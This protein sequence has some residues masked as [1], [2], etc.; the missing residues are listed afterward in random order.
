MKSMSD[1]YRKNFTE[2]NV[3]KQLIH[4]AIPFLLAQLL[5]AFYSLVDMLVVGR[6]MGDM[7]IAAVNNST[8]L[9]MFI[10]TFVSGFA[11]SGTVLV[12]QY[13]GA[14]EEEHAKATIGTMFTLFLYASILITVIG[15][16]LDDTFLKILNTPQEAYLEAKRYL[17]ICFTGTIFICG[18]NGV[19]AVL[20]GLG[21]SK[22]PLYFVAIATGVNIVLD[23]IFV[24]LLH[25]GAGG[26]ALATVL[27]QAL[28]F[29]LCIRTLYKQNFIF[30]FKKE[31]FRIDKR[32]LPLIF[33]IGTPSAIQSGIVNFSFIF[34]ISHI[35]VYGL[36]ASTAAGIGS[37]I[38]SFAILPAIAFS[39]A[40]ATMV[41]QN[42]GAE[43]YDRAKQTLFAG[44]RLS[45]L[46]ALVIF[47]VV[48]FLANPILGM[49]HC[50]AETM[51]IGRE[52]IKLA[53]IAYLFNSI[54]FT[55]NGL[56]NGAGMSLMPMFTAFCNLILARI[57]LIILFSQN[58]GMGLRGI[59]LAMGLSQAT[60]VFISAWFY[61]GGKWK[62]TIIKQGK[63][64]LH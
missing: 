22:R 23:I 37:K 36:A 11:L 63:N 24:G 4:F 31:S 32:K 40:V 33:Q 61:F 47:T 57:P 14:K 52:Y 43:K 62:R 64:A 1:K 8:V 2:G 13:V 10:S 58:M 29:L 55:V 59:F 25:M 42:L 15:L 50:S 18:Y 19:S 27:A 53:T 12:A 28:S 17:V 34:V 41:G 56:A 20:R 38:D 39:Q 6:F 45:F 48:H 51:E 9:T 3:N 46:F 21:D 16:V 5:Q 7:G 49:F 35:N 60:G 44:M 26:A 30:D 54:T